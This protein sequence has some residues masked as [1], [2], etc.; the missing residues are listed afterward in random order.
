MKKLLAILIVGITVTATPSYCAEKNEE[1]KSAL[2]ELLLTAGWEIQSSDKVKENG[3]IISTGKFK[4]DGWYAASVPS[5]V[6]AALCKN[7]V[8]PDPYFGENLRKIPGYQDGIW[9]SMPDNS[10]FRIPYWY[11]TEFRLPQEYIGRKIWLHFDGINY[12]ANIWLN[13]KRIADSSS[14]VGMF[15][16]FA[17]D[18]TD[19]VINGNN[20]LAVQITAPGQSY[21]KNDKE[22][23]MECTSSWD[24]HC[25]YP[26]D[27]NMG[28]WRSVYIRATASV[29]IKNPNVVSKLDL[30]TADV[31]HV[32]I[33]G[34]INNTA[35]KQVTGILRATIS[36]VDNIAQGGTS[37]GQGKTIS[38]CQTVTLKA[39]E[40]REVEFSPDK[41]SELN[42]N[43]P[44]LW[45]PN[46]LGPQ[47]LYKLQLEFEINDEISDSTSI[48]FGIREI[49]THINKKSWR[50][51][52]LNG[53]NILGRGG[54]W[55]TSDL[56]LRFSGKRYES[57]LRYAKE[58]S[59]NLMRVEG[60]SI[61][62][63][64][65]FY[66]MCDK[67]GIMI[68]PEIF[69]RNTTDHKLQLECF[70]DHL[71][72]IRHHPSI[73]HFIGHDETV[74]SRDIDRDYRKLI[75]KYA[76]HI[77][78]Q[79]G[80]GGTAEER[81]GMGGTRTGGPWHFSSPSYYYGQDSKT[82]W[83]I[84]R[85]SYAS[86]ATYSGGIGGET[87]LVE[88]LYKFL[89]KE[90]VWPTSRS[91]WRFHTICSGTWLDGDEEGK[92]VPSF[93]KLLNRRYGQAKNIDEFSYKAQIMTMEAMRALH[94]VVGRNKYECTFLL[95]WKFN[96]PWPTTLSWNV[97][98]WYLAPTGAYYGT[99]K[100]CE[101]L[102]IQYS[103]DNATIYV[104]NNYYQGFEG[105]KVTADLYD[106][107]MA[108]R[109]SRTST[110]NVPPDS[111]NKIFTVERPKDLKQT[112]FI[113]LELKDSL[114]NL[115][116][117]NF[118]WL[119]TQSDDR[120][121]FSDLN[122][123][124]EVDLNISCS[125]ERKGDTCSVFVDLQNPSSTLAFAVNPKIKKSVSG[126]LVL[127][128]CWEDNYFSLLPGEKRR[129]KVNFNIEDLGIEEPLLTIA[130]WNI[131]SEETKVVINR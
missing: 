127:P 37:K 36:D 42:I 118:Y 82:E 91:V 38:V 19:T 79:A 95:T 108:K 75:D 116:S 109:Y 55:M 47:N 78:Y 12:K 30:P 115:V 72:E 92:L 64:P 107:N 131:K 87:A 89:P 73:I 39:G 67:Y 28:I 119:S 102:H 14:V 11:R 32:R 51:I 93:T 16:R 33:S 86:G 65:E 8:F 44:R 100:A 34:E 123:L 27:G 35:N 20:F 60:Y 56:L 50:V 113:K 105:L 54:T 120:V 124:A 129:V 25:P 7:G 85:R 62:E 4:P 18:V 26:P 103:Y 58:M 29:T 22:K 46:P 13:G 70:K 23:D 112:Y 68:A 94:E 21:G 99:K 104:I 74:P 130:G 125:A 57:M 40:V 49:T 122:K 88:N 98:D 81:S 111:S 9:Y 1:G 48:N 121:E 126:D 84:Q 5:T 97:V 66:D 63:L 76:P 17:F 117:S 3:D 90:D 114:D 15:R 77:T 52:Q 45:W 10:P 80:S 6:L 128:I 2:P 43:N 101:P 53:K 61:K 71:L 83:T 69:A 96:A 110:V 59:W 31:A 106:L 24:D 41:F